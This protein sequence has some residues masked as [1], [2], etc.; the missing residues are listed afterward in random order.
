[1]RRSWTRSTSNAAA[2]GLIWLWAELASRVPPI[3]AALRR[4]LLA[5]S[6][7]VECFG[8]LHGQEVES[9]E[10]SR[11]YLAGMIPHLAA[12]SSM[13]PLTMPQGTTNGFFVHSIWSVC[14][15]GS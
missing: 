1:M 11:P 12:A 10:L 7:P 6:M 8:G 2:E 5:V 13:R 9:R 4:R 15:L 3:V 14:T